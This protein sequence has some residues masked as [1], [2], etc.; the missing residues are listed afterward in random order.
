MWA[1]S[2]TVEA[3]LNDAFRASLTAGVSVRVMTESL[4]RPTAMRAWRVTF[5]DYAGVQPLLRVNVTGLR[6]AAQVLVDR[7]SS[8]TVQPQGYWTVQ[9]GGRSTEALALNAPENTVEQ[10]LKDAFP[11]VEDVDVITIPDAPGMLSPARAYPW[12]WVLRFSRP[13]VAGSGAQRCIDPRYV[14]WDPEACP[15][16]AADV[17]LSFF[18]Y[19]WPVMLE[20]PADVA[21]PERQEHL[22]AKC[23]AEAEGLL[24]EPAACHALVPPE[25]LP[26]CGVGSGTTPPCWAERFSRA[27][28][29]LRDGTPATFV[30]DDS[31][32]P[33]D[34][35]KGY[36]FW[37]QEGLAELQRQ[38]A[39]RVNFTRTD[40]AD[41]S[42]QD[43]GMDVR[44]AVSRGSQV[45]KCSIKS[46]ASDTQLE[47][48]LPSVKNQSRSFAHVISED[49]LYNPLA[50][51]RLGKYTTIP[52]MT[53]VSVTHV[54]GALASD[55]DGAARFSNTSFMSLPH[56]Y[57]L[58]PSSCLT[59]ELW[60]RLAEAPA[61][62]HVFMPLVRSIGSDAA[63]GYALI[64]AETG[65]WQFILGIGR[66]SQDTDPRDAYAG[67]LVLEA[68]AFSACSSTSAA[69]PGEWT[70]IAGMYD[71]TE[72]RIYVNGDMSGSV[73]LEP[74]RYRPN[75]DGSVVFGGGCDTVPTSSC[76]DPDSLCAAS[77][78]CTLRCTSCIQ[79]GQEGFLF[80]SAFVGALDE[81]ILYDRALSPNAVK[82][83]ASAGSDT[84][85]A[86][87]SVV[88]GDA[89]STCPAEG[90]CSVVFSST[91]T[92]VISSIEPSSG[93]TTSTV[94][95]HGARFSEG[96]TISV[97]KRE[98]TMTDPPT[99]TQAVCSVQD[100]DPAM[101][102]ALVSL[103]VP[104]RG[105]SANKVAFTLTAHIL[106]VA[107]SLGSRVGG[108]MVTILGT[109]T[110]IHTYICMKACMH[111]RVTGTLIIILSTCTCIHAGAL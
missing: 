81:V 20:Q 16:T 48:V 72:Q 52:D 104:A 91:Q 76:A 55:D 93:W 22:I 83:H 86:T 77:P 90:G 99:D 38:Q 56:S 37:Q 10:A 57:V 68:S 33:S 12:H 23:A 106:S 87:V 71:G 108:T 41:A 8:G 35:Q 88:I 59:L 49:V 85:H 109:Y 43:S 101:G 44:L 46:T 45:T 89:Q 69:V 110:C 98:C 34:R 65:H 13:G 5:Q 29:L 111:F 63:S 61:E 28:V 74:G 51:W 27:T 32:T 30:R 17:F 70:H 94:T 15:S 92:P 26:I 58:N 80:G 102:K 82:G 53:P 97:G 9:M 4:V 50:I 36:R 7:V 40:G 47:I 25:T 66:Q 6:G 11:E 2:T 95:V 73:V 14:D 62:D 103:F 67:M 39:L 84:V 3:Y 42:L 78:A 96:M 31:R 19:Y 1:N 24:I 75:L 105:F 64:V 18:P 107:P 54:P 79:P 21:S 60:V 100:G